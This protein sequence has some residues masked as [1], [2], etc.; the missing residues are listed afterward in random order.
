[1]KTTIRYEKLFN[2][3]HFENEKIGLEIELNI[4]NTQVEKELEITYRQLREKVH[5]FHEKGEEWDFEKHEQSRQAVEIESKQERIK[6]LE[7]EL[8]KLKSQMEAGAVFI[9]TKVE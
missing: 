2:L 8:S 3:G 9:E 6:Q 5:A 4:E 1:M 7:E